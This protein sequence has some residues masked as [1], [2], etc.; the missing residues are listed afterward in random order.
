L[1]R[2]AAVKQNPIVQDTVLTEAMFLYCSV[3]LHFSQN[4][5]CYR[6]KLCY[7]KRLK[8]HHHF[9]SFLCRYN[10]FIKLL[11]TLCCKAAQF[12][13]SLAFNT[14]NRYRFAIANHD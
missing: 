10:N 8:P 4:Y 3:A 14:G 7:L 13:L 6:L 9:L 12:L 2:S 5:K 11:V 1:K